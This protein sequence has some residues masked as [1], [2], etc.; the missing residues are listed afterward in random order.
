ML[1]WSN[2]LG[3]PQRP[4][5]HTDPETGLLVC[6]VCGEA[7]QI[8]IDLPWRKEVVPVACR[9]VRE[10]NAARKEA[11]AQEE[12]AYR[13][14][15][16][17]TSCF[18]GDDRKAG[19]TFATDDRRD[20]Q[21][22]DRVRGYV[23]HFAEFCREGRGLLLLG[24]TG[25]GKTFY[26]C[27]IANALLEAGYSARVT[28]FSQIANELQGTFDKQGVHNALLRPDLLVLDDLAAERDT[29]FMNEIVF[30]VID[31][32]C[33]TQKP[34]IVTSNLSAQAFFKPDSIER[35]RVFS[36]LKEVCIPLSVTGSDRREEQ[37]R[38][39]MADDL[40]RLKS[41]DRGAE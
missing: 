6:G 32:R 9:C 15:R 26:A 4:G 24:P 10:E 18:G 28:N 12:A 27:C 16:R 30:Q 1:T 5:D 38:Q 29:S 35:G 36:R 37:L 19:F 11:L 23:Q 25:T 21:L 34:M 3:N 14:A 31:A 13:L 33:A 7:K 41:K 40:A 2:C 39:R 22:S 20:A 17:R 8:R